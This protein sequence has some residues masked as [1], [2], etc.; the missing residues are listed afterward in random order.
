MRNK[1]CIEKASRSPKREQTPPIW[2]RT[3]HISK[4]MENQRKSIHSRRTTENVVFASRLFVFSFI[5]S[6]VRLF[7]R[8]HMHYTST[9]LPLY[10]DSIQ[11]NGNDVQKRERK[12]K[13]QN[14]NRIIII[15]II[16]NEIPTTTPT[17]AAATVQSVMVEK[18]QNYYSDKSTNDAITI[19][20][21]STTHTH[22]PKKKTIAH[23][24]KR[25]SV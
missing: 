16:C 22:K 21:R 13:Y 14:K 6:L 7:I 24:W 1:N 4:N 20:K 11:A 2:Q 5:H 18:R 19:G 15:T 17:A 12:K 3:K 8:T 25:A 23:L 10:L 9:L